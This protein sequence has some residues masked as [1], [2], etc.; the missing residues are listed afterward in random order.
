MRLSE[1]DARRRA[2][3]ARS[4]TLATVDEHG[5]PHIVPVVYALADDRL[6][7][8]VDHKP[9]A[10]TE[11]KRLRNIAAHP[12]VSVLVDAY[13]EDWS[14]LWWVRMDGTARIVDAEDRRR[15]AVAELGA[16]YQQYRDRPP[17][18]P[19]V[20]ILIQTWRGWAATDG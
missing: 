11:L 2:G 5:H 17:A 18:G 14:Q 6:W 4:A 16:K 8:A 15:S 19:V 3:A 1:A 9:K 13:D 12:E 7:F 10:T 20:E